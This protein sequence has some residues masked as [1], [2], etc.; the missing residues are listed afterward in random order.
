MFRKL[1]YM[2]LYRLHQQDIYTAVD[3]F[4]KYLI[5]YPIANKDSPT[6]SSALF[7]LVCNYRICEMLISDQGTEFK[8][9]VA[10]ELYNFLGITQKFTLSFVHHCLVACELT[11]GNIAARM[12]PYM[13]PNKKN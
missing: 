12:T 7:Q 8:A 11:H 1:I 9:K 4:S 2:D 10:A 5:A 13:S 3:M 6:V